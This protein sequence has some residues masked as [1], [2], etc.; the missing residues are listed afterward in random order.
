MGVRKLKR[1]AIMWF[2]LSWASPPLHFALLSQHGYDLHTVIDF[3]PP[4]MEEARSS[5]NTWPMLGVKNRLFR[6]S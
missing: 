5:Q 4:C 2:R 6:S 1:S 3:D